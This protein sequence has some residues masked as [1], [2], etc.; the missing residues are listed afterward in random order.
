MDIVNPIPPNIPAPK[1][2]FHFKSLGS[3]QIPIV[4]A[5]KEK[6]K[7]PNGLPTTSPSIIP[8][9]F[10]WLNP[11][12]QLPFMAMQVLAMANN[13]RI[14]KATGLCRKCCNRYDEVFFPP[15][16]NGITNANR[17]PVMVA[18]TPEFSMKY[19]MKAPPIKYGAR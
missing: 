17:T 1:I 4:T 5:K 15:F 2:F 10:A 14:K 16:P 3:L 9:E 6:R 7:I 19:H 11:S 8:I 13:G 12:C 18:C